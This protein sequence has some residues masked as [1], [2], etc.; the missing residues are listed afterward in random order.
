M[1]RIRLSCAK[2][3]SVV[4]PSGG[5]D[6]GTWNLESSRDFFPNCAISP[7]LC[8]FCFTLTL[9]YFVQQI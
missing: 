7:F 5:L 9:L 3:L 1:P 4:S 8:N 2:K 6:F